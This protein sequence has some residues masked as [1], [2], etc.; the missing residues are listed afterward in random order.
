MGKRLVVIIMTRWHSDDIIGRLTDPENPVYSEAEAKKWKIIRLP[1]IAED[2]DD[3]MG[4]ATGELL[5]PGSSFDHEYAESLRNLDPLGYA[6]LQQQRP[7][8]ADGVMFRRENIRFYD[9]LPER[10][11]IYGA[12]DHAVAEKQRNDRSCFGL[13]GVDETDD[14]YI[15]PQL[16]WNRS[17]ADVAVEHMLNRLKGHK[18]VIWWAEKGHISKSIGPFLRKRM[19][20]TGVWGNV[21]DVTPTGDK[22]ARAQAIAAR[23]AIGKV[24]LPRNAPWTE[25]AVSELLAFP[26]GIFDDF[27][28][29]ISLLGLGLQA[30]WGPGKKAK[31][32]PEPAPYTL[33]WVKKYEADGRLRQPATMYMRGF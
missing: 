3:P 25:R 23:M 5:W 18:P 7:T 27:V 10:L 21:V 13:G 9:T 12:S 1:L 20:E 24:L 4:R 22:V 8:V 33:A 28:D 16:T 11:T 26:N 14:L 6:A 15:L 19:L 2:E 30:Q 17:P 29:M 32:E 31:E